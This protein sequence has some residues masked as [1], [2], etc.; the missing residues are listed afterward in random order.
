MTQEN[1]HK[2]I[3]KMISTNKMHKMAI[4]TVVDD[5]GI[6]RGRHQ[7]LMHLARAE[8]FSSQKELAEHLGIT[9]AAVTMA[10]SKLERDGLIKRESGADNRFNEII[11]TDRGRDIIEHSRNHFTEVDSDT[12]ANFTEEELMLFSKCL[13]KMQENLKEV[14]ERKKTNEKMV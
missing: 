6:G 11:I 10:L 14:I 12:F 9:Q 13:D 5:I 8:R 2:L 7:I 3:F 1:I 4:E